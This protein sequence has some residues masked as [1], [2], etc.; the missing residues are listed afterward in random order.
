MIS[1][2]LLIYIKGETLMKV[3]KYMPI[4][5]ALVA[6]AIAGGSQLSWVF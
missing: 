3:A 2:G 6:L 5:F 4:V 1:G